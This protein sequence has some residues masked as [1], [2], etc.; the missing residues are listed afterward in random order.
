MKFLCPNSLVKVLLFCGGLLIS[1]VKAD[2]ANATPIWGINAIALKPITNATPSLA[3]LLTNHCAVSLNRFYRAGGIN[4]PA[5]PTE[6]RVTYNQ[7]NLFVIF[8]CTENDMTF[9]AIRRSTNWFAFLGSPSEQD[10]EFPDKVDLFIQPNMNG[11]SYY[12]FA[13]T[14]DGLKFGCKRNDKSAET[15]EGVSGS[16]RTKT[17]NS[18]EATVTKKTNEWIVCLRIPW[19]TLGGKPKNCFGLLPVRTRWRDGEVSSPV[20]F[21]FTERP[22]TDLFI[23]THL[24]ETNPVRA[25]QT[26]LCRL[27]SGTLR[28]QRPAQLTYPDA[29]TVRQIWQME[30][31]LDAPTDTNN[32]AQRLYLTRCWINLLTLEGFNFRAGIGS[33]AKRHMEPAT[34]RRKINNDLRK[35]RTRRAYQLLDIFLRKL[36]R[37]SRDWFADSSPGDILTNEWQPISKLDGLEIKGHVLCMHGVAGEHRVDLHLSLP[38]TGGVRIYGDDEGYFKP[39]ALL[40]LNLFQSTNSCS[41]K[42]AGGKITIGENPFVIS[43]FDA[44]G[45]LTTRIAPNAIAFRFDSN[46]KVAAVDFKN[47][48]GTNEVIY[49]F[50]ERYDRFNENGSVLTLWGIDDWVGNTVGLMNE[51]YKPIPIL[52]SSCGYMIF[53]NSTYRLR[54]DIGKSSSNQYRLTQQGPIFDYYFWIGSPKSAIESYTALTGKPILPPKWAFEPWIGRK[55]DAWERTPLHDPVAEEE[56]VVKRFEALDIPHSAIYAEGSSADSPELNS[57]MAAHGIRVLSW[58]YPGISESTQEKLMPKLKPDELPLLHTQSNVSWQLVDFTN[59]HA[60]ELCRRWWQHRLDIGVAG[61]MVDFGDRVPEDAVFYNGERGDEMHNFYS[62][63]YQ[64]TYSEVFRGKRG[65]DFILFGRAAAPGTQTFVAQF[66]GD[67]PANF[68]GLRAVFTGALNLCACG[69]STWGSD[70]GGFLGWPEPEVYMRWTQFACFSPLMRSHGRTPREPWNFGNEAV[71]NYKFY[72]WVRENLLDYIY[73]T[74][75]EAHQTGVPIMRSMAVAFPGEQSLAA[76][77][78]EYM[79]GDDLLVAPVVS[80]NNQRTISFPR[81]RWISLWTSQIVNGPT[82]FTSCVPLNSIPVYL[83]S[84]AIVPVDLNSNLQFGESMSAGKVKALIVTP[85]IEKSF[86]TDGQAGKESAQFQP[87]ADGF[88]VSLKNISEINYLLVYGATAVSSVK[89]DGEKMPK[90]ASGNF[91]STSSGWTK[92]FAGSRLIIRLPKSEKA[93]VKI[94]VRF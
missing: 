19:K 85:P 91:D 3:N 43:F 70:L 41:I 86:W 89:L 30:Q 73:D 2:F 13:V 64:R 51:T 75:I 38:K 27:P 49:G 78:D 67:H 72:A 63:D 21:D 62:Y 28:W 32:F 56:S 82:N 54:A 31:S 9:P 5:R 6:C 59:P 26:T 37:T 4:L 53:D 93:T 92:D 90:L 57:F 66:A 29:K 22:P 83:K 65:N 39:D 46:G 76:T 50:G 25:A 17:I 1:Q 80:E 14:L 44:T 71:A 20:A 15:G 55:G 12:Q 79:F 68:S 45:N 87:E 35:K 18:F 81:G 84:G 58:F 94:E 10:S 33:I 77:D 88:T 40:P 52:H 23:E 24:D 8:R 47:H 69:F 7:K 36:D 16:V 60:L 61:S 11:R 74:A 48:L 42:T 34:V